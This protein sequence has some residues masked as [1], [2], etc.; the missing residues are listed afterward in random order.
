MRQSREAGASSTSIASASSAEVVPKSVSMGSTPSAGG[1]PP[2]DPAD[3]RPGSAGSL[4]SAEGLVMSRA[5]IFG[6][7]VV[8]PEAI[9]ASSS[10]S[11]LYLRGT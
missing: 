9:L 11:S 4:I 5:K 3:E 1:F 2:G 8:R 10:A 7:M 6:G